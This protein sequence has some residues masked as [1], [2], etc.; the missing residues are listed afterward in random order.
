M[1]IRLAAIALIVVG[2]GAIVLVVVGPAI[3]ASSS[4]QYITAT[5][6]SG[7][8]VSA[9]SVATGT[10]EAS[11]VYGLVFGS[12]AD[13]VSSAATTSGTGGSTSSSNSNSARP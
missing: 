5:V 9:Q 13:I 1:K 4:S 6:T 2:V 7:T 12:S 11:T 8:T 10:V 3:G